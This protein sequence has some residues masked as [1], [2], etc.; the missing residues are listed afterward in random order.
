M[1]LSLSI[2]YLAWLKREEADPEAMTWLREE[3][4]HVNRVLRVNGLPEHIEPQ[5]L[6]EM[7]GR[8]L[9]GFPYSWLHYLRRAVA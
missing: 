2:G 3:L 7:V 9:S 4:A 8:G 5:E 6:P 1:G